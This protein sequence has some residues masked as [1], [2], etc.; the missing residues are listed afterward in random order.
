MLS[1]SSEARGVSLDPF[2]REYGS[3]R[4]GRFALH[5][6]SP[7][8]EINL[9]ARAGAGVQSFF[10]QLWLEQTQT[11]WPQPQRRRRASHA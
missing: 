3:R 8:Q 4:Q 10:H 6:M 7:P 5:A 9:G 2:V 11:G 1:T